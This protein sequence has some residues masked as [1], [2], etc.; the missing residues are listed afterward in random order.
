MK[1][2]KTLRFKAQDARFKELN[3][4][5]TDPF[6][7]ARDRFSRLFTLLALCVTLSLPTDCWAAPAAENA[8]QISSEQIANL[9]VKL[10]KLTPVQ[11]IPGLYAPAK[12]VIPPSREYVVSA[13][14]AG[15]INQLLV[16]VG[17][18][19]EKGAVLA[20]VSSPDLLVLQQQYLKAASDLQLSQSA[21]NR[22]QKMLAEGVIAERRWQETRSQHS[23]VVSAAHEA[24][25]LLAVAGMPEADINR[26]ARTR[27]FNSVLTVYA[28]IAGV[29]LEQMAA[30]GESINNLAPLYRLA[31]LDELWLDI[32]IPQERI[33]SIKVGDQ[34][35]V[36]NSGLSAHISLLGQSV[37]AE[38]QTLLARAV[39]K[40]A[41]LP[42]RPG[43]KI[44]VQIIQAIEKQAFKV[45]H[46]AIAQNEG[47]AFIFVRNEQGFKVLPVTVIGKQETDS[48]INGDLLGNENIAI[49]GAVAL[50]ANWLGLGSE[51]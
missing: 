32:N 42:V 43:Q 11:Q 33:G 16:A 8:I 19:V 28:P 26:L 40:G 27:R 29:V 51:E 5:G 18:K 47:K 39:I 37:N 6:Y 20:R 17:D 48:I 41:P 2:I 10:G 24:R 50:K 38:N 7:C 30:T 44:T 46:T 49:N 31:N 34:V 12:V 9:G 23:T 25:Q 3:N 45:P 14:A 15:V 22:D 4:D 13:S 21:Y 36:E 1:I 35:A